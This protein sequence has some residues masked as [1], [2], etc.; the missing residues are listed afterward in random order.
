MI[1]FNCDW[2]ALY[3]YFVFRRKDSRTITHSQAELHGF[4]KEHFSEQPD[5]HNPTYEVEND[6]DDDSVKYD[7]YVVNEWINKIN[8]CVCCK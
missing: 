6:S 4:S 5:F 1:W 7:M 2:I 8:E 3:I